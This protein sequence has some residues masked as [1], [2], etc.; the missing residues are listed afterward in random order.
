MKT[1]LSAFSMIGRVDRILNSKKTEKIIENVVDLSW[2]NHRKKSEEFGISS[3]K[4][5]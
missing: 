2:V 5:I 4:L 3:F 1:T